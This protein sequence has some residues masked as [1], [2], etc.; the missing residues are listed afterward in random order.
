MSHCNGLS[1]GGNTCN[2]FVFSPNSLTHTG[3]YTCWYHQFAAGFDPPTQCGSAG[4]AMYA[5]LPSGAV[6]S[7]SP[8]AEAKAE[9]LAEAKAARADALEL[10]T[11]HRAQ[12][13]ERPGA[14]AL[15]WPSARALYTLGG[16]LCV[17]AGLLVIRRDRR[18]RQPSKRISVPLDD[19]FEFDDGIAGADAGARAEAEPTNGMDSGALV[20]YLNALDAFY[21]PPNR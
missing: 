6:Q 8:L 20:R 15:P 14:H 11:P 19:A 1:S 18:Q 4:H 5:A 17:I 2:G 21:P 10:Y 7:P 9:P 16:C 12:E 3:T 13:L